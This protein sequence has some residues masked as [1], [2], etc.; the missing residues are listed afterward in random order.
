MKPRT[1]LPAGDLKYLGRRCQP[2]FLGQ[3]C[4]PF[5]GVR[6]AMIRV[7]KRWIL[8]GKTAKILAD[9]P[10]AVCA[11]VGDAPVHEY[12]HLPEIVEHTVQHRLLLAF[13]CLRQVYRPVRCF[14]LRWLRAALR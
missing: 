13:C 3:R 4:Y 6:V 11:S 2:V 12:V 9:S 14:R 8:V 10:R 7:G 5:H 1:G